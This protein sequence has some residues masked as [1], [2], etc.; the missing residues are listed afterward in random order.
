MFIIEKMAKRK[1]IPKSLKTYVAKRKLKVSKEPCAKLVKRKKHLPIFVV[2]KHAAS[3]LHY[4]LRLEMDEVLKSWAIPKGPSMNPED[5]RLAVHVEDHP[6]EYKDFEG[7]IPEG[8]GAGKVIVWDRG[9]YTVEDSEDSEAL[10]REGWERGSIHLVFYGKKLKG[11]F[12][13]V[14]MKNRENDWLLIKKKD[15]F[16]SDGDIRQKDRSVLSRKKVE[17]L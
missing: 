11:A 16:S 7:I 6:Y 10:A 12:T 13:L 15:K 3:R 5:K 1:K 17:N 2:Q 4:D 9:I 14:K 8:Y